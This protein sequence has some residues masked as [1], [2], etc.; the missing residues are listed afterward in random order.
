MQPVLCCEEHIINNNFQCKLSYIYIRDENITLTKWSPQKSHALTG[1]TKTDAP[2]EDTF[3][4]CIYCEI[5]TIDSY[6]SG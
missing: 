5:T 1:V 4:I 6:L 2:N 3:K